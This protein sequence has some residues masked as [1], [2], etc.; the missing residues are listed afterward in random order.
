MDG[1]AQKE[2]MNLKE[3]SAFLGVSPTTLREMM[4]D[5]AIP[6]KQ[7]GRRYFFSKTVLMSWLSGSAQGVSGP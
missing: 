3:A 7:F 5:G 2:V 4:N 6:Y 1:E